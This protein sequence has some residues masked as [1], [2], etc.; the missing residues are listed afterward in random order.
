MGFFASTHFI[1][2]LENNFSNKFWSVS[3]HSVSLRIKPVPVRPTHCP[4]AVQQL[5]ESAAC[6]YPSS[7]QI[8]RRP[9]EACAAPA[10]APP[11]H[12]PIPSRRTKKIGG[13]GIALAAIGLTATAFALCLKPR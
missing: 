5:Y 3:A 7:P 13:K 6:V 10:F 1:G 12:Q 2:L 11:G 8:S 4:N 9:R